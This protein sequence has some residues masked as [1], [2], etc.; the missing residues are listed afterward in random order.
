M[1][2]DNIRFGNGEKNLRNF[3][4]FCFLGGMIN[5]GWI[6]KDR[7]RGACGPE[8]AEVRGSGCRHLAGLFYS[9]LT[10]TV[11][12]SSSRPAADSLEHLQELHCSRHVTTDLASRS[13]NFFILNLGSVDSSLRSCYCLRAVVLHCTV[14]L[15]SHC[16]IKCTSTLHLSFPRSIPSHYT[17]TYKH[18]VLLHVQS[19]STSHLNITRTIARVP[20]HY[21]TFFRHCLC[22]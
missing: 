8:I 18:T 19:H 3:R 1:S 13:R 9:H 16:T 17:V 22:M 7:P 11:I 5:R 21:T 10:S 4:G 14:L 2:F 6:L 15:P 12:L 20:S